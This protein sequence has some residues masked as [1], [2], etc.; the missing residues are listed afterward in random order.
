MFLNF[1]SPLSKKVIWTDGSRI[2]LDRLR[3][4]YAAWFGHAFEAR[5]N[6]DAVAVDIP[7]FNDDV[8]QVDPDTQYDSLFLGCCGLSPAIP[9]CSSMAQ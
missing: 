4:Q 3:N 1:R 8:T 5:R 9:F 6:V 2:F 7:V